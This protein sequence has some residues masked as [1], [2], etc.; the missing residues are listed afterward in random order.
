MSPGKTSAHVTDLTRP[1]LLSKTYV[2]RLFISRSDLNLWKSSYASFN[3]VKNRT[4]ANVPHIDAGDFG[5][6]GIKVK[7]EISKKYTLAIRVN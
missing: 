5:L 3:I 6:K 2:C 4:R 1:E 7:T